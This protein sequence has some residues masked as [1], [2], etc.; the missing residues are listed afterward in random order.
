MWANGVQEQKLQVNISFN[1]IESWLSLTTIKEI[2][3]FFANE[4][5]E[6]KLDDITINHGI[7]CLFNL[8]NLIFYF[9]FEDS[10]KLWNLLIFVICGSVSFVFLQCFGQKHFQCGEL[11]NGSIGNLLSE[12]GI[13][14]RVTCLGTCHSRSIS[15]ILFYSINKGY[16][17]SLWFR[18]LFSLDINEPIAEEWSRPFALVIFP[19]CRMVE[20]GH[21][22]VIFYQVFPWTTQVEGIPI[23]EWFSQLFHFVHCH[24]ATCVRQSQK[25]I[26]PEISSKILWLDSQQSWL[27]AIQISLQVMRD[28]VKCHINCAV[29]KRFNQILWVKGKLSSEAKWSRTS[30]FMQPV[31]GVNQIIVQ[32]VWVAFK[33]FLNIAKY[34]LFP[35]LI[36]VVNIPLVTERDNTVITWSWNY[37]AIGLIILNN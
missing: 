19:N 14:N 23:Q 13:I 7:I 16:E 25:Y 28:C 17:I 22:Q 15:A 32:S 9:T 3:I 18:H 26:I 31:N 4:L 8:S 29:G 12:V 1:Q 24:F 33:L 2:C 34:S 21:C 20:Q 5:M 30:P 35:L 6:A 37:I 10:V 27:R 11:Q 36:C